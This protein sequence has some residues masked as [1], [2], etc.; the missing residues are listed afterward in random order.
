M[1]YIHDPTRIGGLKN[2]ISIN[3]GVELDL[4][5]QE[6]GESAGSRQLSG[7]GGQM[8]FLEGA[9]RS[10]GGQGYI[11]LNATHTRK[12]GSL[13]SNI[14]PCVPAG[15]TV[16]VPRTMVE[17]VVTEY[18]VAELAGKSLGERARAMAA[19]AHPDF[20][21]ELLRYAREKLGA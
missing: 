14:V 5:G 13:K 4:M 18:G 1:D 6:N 8:D 9:Y 3:G 7:I 21:E 10:P 20:R 2:V 11:C 12:D 16:S 15:S 19:I 17:C